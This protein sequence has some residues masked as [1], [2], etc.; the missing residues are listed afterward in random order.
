MQHT[1]IQGIFVLYYFCI[2]L[3]IILPIHNHISIL[4]RYIKEPD[5]ISKFLYSIYHPRN[6]PSL[7]CIS[8]SVVSYS[9]ADIFLFLY[10]HFFYPCIFFFYFVLSFMWLFGLTSFSIHTVI[11]NISNALI[12]KMEYSW[13][14]VI[15]IL[16]GIQNLLELHKFSNYRSS[17]YFYQILK[18][19]NRGC[20]FMMQSIVQAKEEQY[21][22]ILFIRNVYILFNNIIVKI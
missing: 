1:W 2:I 20:S 11:F 12:F 7:I 6:F 13:S 8:Y 18:K 10:R 4:P 9:V 16:K 21:I 19:I 22:Q 3:C 5:S 15:R 14:H 17:D